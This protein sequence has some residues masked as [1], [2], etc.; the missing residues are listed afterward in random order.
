MGQGIPFLICTSVASADTP[1]SRVEWQ[2][3]S[4]PASNS[5]V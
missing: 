5:V 3:I 1:A 2:E 4:D